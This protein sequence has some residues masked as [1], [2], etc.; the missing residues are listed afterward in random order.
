MREAERWTQ[1]QFKSWGLENVHAEGFDFGR[2]WWIESSSLRMT[3]PRPID[4]ARDPGGV[5]AGEQRHDLAR[6]SSSRR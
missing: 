1:Q 4:A 6:R 2:G 3:A 5:D